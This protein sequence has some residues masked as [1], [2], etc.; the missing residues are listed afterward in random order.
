MIQDW[1]D[2]RSDTVT[3]PDAEMRRA[4]AEAE[5]GDDVYGE[6]PT[7][8]RLEEEAAAGGGHGGGALRPLRHDGQPDRP[9]PPRPARRRGDLRRGGPH[10]PLRDGRH[11]GALGPAA[12]RLPSPGRAARSGGG[13][14]GDPPDV[15][16]RA[17]HRADR[18][19]EHPQHGGRHGLRAAA[20]SRRILD[21]A[22]PAPPARPPA[23]AP[24]S[25]TP[26]RRWASPRPR[27]P[28]A[29]TR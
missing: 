20:R 4:M 29:S 27:W 23:T 14:G 5:V 18:G 8:L 28:P 24:A 11:G 16:Y 17:A 3:Q 22:A 9:P 10:P 25:S 1:I 12:A 15:A 7:V 21:V 6:D 2:L 19:R 26:P 13:R